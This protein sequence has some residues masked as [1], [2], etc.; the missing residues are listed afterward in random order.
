MTF[1]EFITL[2]EKCFDLFQYDVLVVCEII[3][4][5]NSPE[6]DSQNKIT[7][8]FNFYRARNLKNLIPN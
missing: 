3:P 4:F 5:K 6:N 1:D 7:G 8:G 2:A